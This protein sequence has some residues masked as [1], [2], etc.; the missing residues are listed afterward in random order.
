MN[1]QLEKVSE[2]FAAKRKGRCQIDMPPITA[3]YEEYYT[4][5][6][7]RF[8]LLAALQTVTGNRSSVQC[9]HV[10]ERGTDSAQTDYNSYDTGPLR[11]SDLIM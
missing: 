9:F 5:G 8:L 3:K 10:T 6:I 2:V 1:V 4:I 7:L 11:T